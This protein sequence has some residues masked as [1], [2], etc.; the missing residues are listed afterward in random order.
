LRSGDGFGADRVETMKAEAIPGAESLH[1]EFKS[2]A[3]RLK[4]DEL[5][6]AVVCLANTDGGTIYVGVEDDGTVTGLLPAHQDAPGMA[7]MIASKT[8]PPVGVRVSL[9][10]VEGKPIAKVDVPR[11]T[12]L[13]SS[14][15]GTLQRR[16]L[17]ADGKPECVPFL[18]HEFAAHE[19]DLR[20][21]DYSSLPV[22]GATVD[23]FDPAER[24]RLRQAIERYRGDASLVGLSDGELDGALGLARTQGRERVPT[25][26]GLLM[27]G[28]ESAIRE[29]LPT[30]EV[31]FQ[32]LDGT[33]VK[34]NDFF[35]WPLV[36]LF[37]RVEELFRA[38]VREEELQSGLFRV[39]VPNVD[40]RSFREAFVNAV[41][42][43]DYSR[44][45]TVYVRWQPEV[46]SIS[47][48]GGFVE[49]VTLENLLTVEPRPRNPSLADTFKRIG[50]A[51]RTG[52]GVDLIYQGLLRYGRPAPSYRRSD[53]TTVVVE[54]SCAAADLTFLAAVLEQERKLGTA[55]PLEHLLVLAFL[56]EARR[57]DAREVA[58]F[59][60]RGVGPARAVIERLVESGLVVAHGVKR[61]RT[62]TL[63]PGVYKGLGRSAEYV[64]QAGFDSVQ[65]EEMAVNFAKAHGSIR[66]QDVVDLCGVNASQATRLL[67]RLA[68][69]GR[70]VRRGRMKGTFYEPG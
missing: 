32:E 7:A 44:L 12:R 36:R 26:L 55:I 68:S 67:S 10:T 21:V 64:R 38:R 34:A 31:A 6:L 8:V 57:A 62:Y 9:L 23:V 33:D 1:V 48:P 53:A 17:M 70:L 61:G 30:H 54:L 45:G 16:R 58:G 63:S 60:R 15:R 65:Q 69:K 27:I 5:V 24:Y 40:G 47:S 52:R 14:S 66:R 2:D 59:L 11:S 28:K 37:E 25:V 42:H 29:H 13:V 50:L 41:T 49:G 22:A 19:S 51:E 46:L 3:K 4:D 39:P 18:P 35:R 43:R 20:L 56:R